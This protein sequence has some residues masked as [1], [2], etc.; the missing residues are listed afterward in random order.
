MTAQENKEFIRRYLKALSGKPKPP[1]LVNQ[2]VD[3]QP[4]RDH[5]A[6][7]EQGFPSYTLEADRMLAEDDLVSVI[8]RFGGTHTGAFMG[9]PPTGKTFANVP[10]HI[11]Y[12]I[13]GGRIVEHWLL[14]DTADLMQKLGL[15]PSAA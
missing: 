11:T 2:F 1:E 10:V 6:A 12:R 3:D 5:I 7:G 13:Q 14:F 15:V 4:L 9:I 8:G